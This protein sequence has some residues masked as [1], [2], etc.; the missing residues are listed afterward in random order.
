MQPNLAKYFLDDRHVGYI[1]K[2]LRELTI[3]MQELAMN[4]AVP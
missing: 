3:F 1:T 4:S 2:F